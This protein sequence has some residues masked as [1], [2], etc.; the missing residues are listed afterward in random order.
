M[1]P[2]L[3]QEEGVGI[4]DTH[5]DLT[6]NPD[7]LLQAF[8]RLEKDQR[9]PS[10][11]DV[12]AATA[13]T[14]GAARHELD[15]TRHPLE[16]EEDLTGKTAVQFRELLTEIGPESGLEVGDGGISLQRPQ[17]GVIPRVVRDEGRSRRIRQRLTVD[18]GQSRRR[19]RGD[20]RIRLIASHEEKGDVLAGL[21]TG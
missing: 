21:E 13:R 4:G 7:D 17:R 5:S 12:A 15:A 2:S 9:N 1:P 14:T 11:D 10:D 6:A 3:L 19:G 8:F 16:V 18:A 20:H